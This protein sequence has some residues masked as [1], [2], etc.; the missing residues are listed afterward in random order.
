MFNKVAKQQIFIKKTRLKALIQWQW[1]SELFFCTKTSCLKISYKLRSQAMIH[2]LPITG[3]CEGLHSSKLNSANWIIRKYRKLHV[4]VCFARL[5][6]SSCS[7]YGQRVNC[8]E[9]TA[10][11]CCSQLLHSEWKGKFGYTERKQNY[12]IKKEKRKKNSDCYYLSNRKMIK[13]VF[14]S[15]V[16]LLS[17][18]GSMKVL[19]A[20]VC[21]FVTVLDLIESGVFNVFMKLI[22]TWWHLSL[23]PVGAFGNALRCTYIGRLS[24]VMGSLTEIYER[25]FKY[26]GIS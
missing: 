19:R 12:V 18:C 16:S 24:S 10:G 2:H 21:S 8:F 22:S 6:K 9:A 11:S 13:V 15:R 25:N 23:I 26:L 20:Q 3:P 5:V 17:F 1:R 4:R 7:N 14:S